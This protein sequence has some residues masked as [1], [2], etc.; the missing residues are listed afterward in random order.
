MTFEP[1]KGFGNML[2]SRHMEKFRKELNGAFNLSFCQP[3]IWKYA[4]N[5]V[6]FAI[7]NHHS[8]DYF[9]F[10]GFY[11]KITAIPRYYRSNG[12]TGK[13]MYS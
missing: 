12:T 8:F 10:F 5:I 7:T 9:S 3:L 13:A 4:K 11:H 2:K 6:V 1:S